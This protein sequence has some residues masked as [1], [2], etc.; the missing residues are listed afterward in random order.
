MIIYAFTELTRCSCKTRQYY[1]QACSVICE[2]SPTLIHVKVAH[3]LREN[4]RFI[5]TSWANR[6][7]KSPRTRWLSL[8]IFSRLL[9]HV[10]D[11]HL[12]SMCIYMWWWRTT[13]ANYIN[14]FQIQIR[15]EFTL[16]L[17]EFHD[18]PSKNGFGTIHVNV[19]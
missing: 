5:V 6:F 8:Y 7:S 19:I 18:H 4:M 16:P 1:V 13:A 14:W 9:V 3:I 12:R 17:V 2:V 10:L 11:A 15:R